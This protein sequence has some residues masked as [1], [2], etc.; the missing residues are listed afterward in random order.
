[1]D[2]TKRSDTSVCQHH[3]TIKS[4]IDTIL[5]EIT[6]QGERLKEGD[7]R[8][9]EIQ[10]FIIIKK[11]QNGYTKEEIREF[12]ENKEKLTDRVTSLEKNS[13]TKKELKT[14]EDKL[15]SKTLIYINTVIIALF[16]LSILIENAKDAPIMHI[17]GL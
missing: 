4:G 15:P 12:K 10:E 5:Q 11:A 7:K 17:L 16:V 9:Q 2:G 6:N 13:A 3:G 8:F 1:M 14:I